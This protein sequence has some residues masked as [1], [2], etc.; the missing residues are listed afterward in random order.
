MR[1]LVSGALRASARTEK[2]REICY[3]SNVRAAG[4]SSS[5]ADAQRSAN[6][7]SAEVACIVCEQFPYE[8]FAPVFKVVIPA[9]AKR[10]KA[11]RNLSHRTDDFWQQRLVLA[12][13]PQRESKINWVGGD[14]GDRLP[15]HLQL[16]RR[17]AVQIRDYQ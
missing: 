10:A 2:R 12:E 4:V 3:C 7:D 6:E 11:T 9:N 8:R 14:G 5:P 1:S 15:Q 17:V 13:I 16:V